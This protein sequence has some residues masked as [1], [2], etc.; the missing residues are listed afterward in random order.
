[1]SG[2]TSAAL[3]ASLRDGLGSAYLPL[4]GPVLEGAALLLRNLGVKAYPSCGELLMCIA[5]LYGS[6]ALRGHP[7]VGAVRPLLLLAVGAAAKVFGPE[8][9]VA[10]LPI[11]VGTADAADDSSWLL[12]ALK[13]HIG[14]AKLVRAEGLERPWLLAY[15]IP[16]HP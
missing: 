5:S 1:M 10:V 16:H 3:A 15:P 7:D 2:E 8:T 12:Y 4:W 14:H 13:G 6:T 9:F 11:R